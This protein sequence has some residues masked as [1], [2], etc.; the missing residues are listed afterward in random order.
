MDPVNDPLGLYTNVVEKSP[1]DEST[2]LKEKG[3]TDI[4]RRHEFLSTGDA[5]PRLLSNVVDE[6]PGITDINRELEFPTDSLS[7]VYN[8]VNKYQEQVLPQLNQGASPSQRKSEHDS[9]SVESKSNKKGIHDKLKPYACNTCGNRFTKKGGL[10]AHQRI[11]Y[12]DKPY[13]CEA[14]PKTFTQQGHLN[15]HIKTHTGLR[16]YKC[17]VCNKEFKQSGQL[18]THKTR[19]VHMVMVKKLNKK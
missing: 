18:R 6:Y 19:R 14:C 10:T 8:V 5:R 3:I 12:N 1:D 7:L 15:D 13:E 16:P 4:N 2:L 17:E 11:H 9:I